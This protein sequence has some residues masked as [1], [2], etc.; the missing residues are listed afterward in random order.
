MLHSPGTNI[1]FAGLKKQ[2]AAQG[3]SLFALPVQD[4]NK[5]F[6]VLEGV[7]EN[8]DLLMAIPDSAIYNSGSI[9]NILLTSYRK[10]IPLVG[11]SQHYVDAGALC[12]IFSTT[13]QIAEQAGATVASFA[14]NRHLP[15]PQY[16]ANF[17]VAVNHQVARSMG[18]KLL[19]SEIIR[20]QMGKAVK[21]P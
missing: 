20:N 8:S 2:I 7:L 13:E 15:P 3:G 18:I 12:A 4:I 16:P 21:R 5:L 19:S 6:P 14:R 1:D 9:R 11:L 10:N 17:T